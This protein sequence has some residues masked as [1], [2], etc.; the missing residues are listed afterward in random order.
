M[1]KA[2]SKSWTVTPETNPAIMQFWAVPPS[3]WMGPDGE[4]KPGLTTW[5]FQHCTEKPG[6][7]STTDK[8]LPYHTGGQGF[9]LDMAKDF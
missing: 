2:S 4:T 6:G 5:Y 1:Q 9:N 7:H 3:G 8:A